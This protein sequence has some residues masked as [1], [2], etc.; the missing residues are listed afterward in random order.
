MRIIELD[1]A[2]WKSVLDFYN[3]LLAALGAP[4][5]H[6]RN[7]NALVDSMIWG[8]MNAIEAP[9]TIRLSQTATLSQDIRDH[10]ELIERVFVEA[11]ADF[12]NLRGHDIDV[13]WEVN[14]Q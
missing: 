13:V 9:Y 10:F 3:A 8:G 12:R 1:A 14:A 11:R 6:G 5:G 4:R 2:N 7:I